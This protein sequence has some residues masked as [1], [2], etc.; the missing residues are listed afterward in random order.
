MRVLHRLVTE[1]ALPP[2]A[3]RVGTV[4]LDRGGAATQPGTPCICLH[5]ATPSATP[6]MVTPEQS[7]P[8]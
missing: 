4:R 3:Y 2:N 1:L 7:R 6:A 8:A 5:R